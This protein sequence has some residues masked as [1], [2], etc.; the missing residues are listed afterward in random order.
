MATKQVVEQTD[1]ET[2]IFAYMA[3]F[4]W[5]RENVGMALI[6]FGET[7]GQDKIDAMIRF[8]VWSEKNKRSQG[9]IAAQIGHD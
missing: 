1:R 8:V 5:S 2:I 3:E 9:W 4:G 7:H 6:T